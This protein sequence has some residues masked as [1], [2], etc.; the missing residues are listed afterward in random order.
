M[1]EEEEKPVEQPQTIDEK[2][3]SLY[4]DKGGFGSL[5]DTY[6]D[7]KRKYPEIKLKDVQTWYRKNVDFNIV[8]R[9]QNSF[10]AQKPHQEYQLDL[11]N[12]RGRDL[13]YTMGVACID[14]FSKFA[15]VVALADKK[16]E[17]LL[18]AIQ[19]VFQ[20]MGA[21]PLVLMSDEEGSLQS[22]LAD[23]YL[24][25]EK[26]KYIINRNH[27]PFVE[28]FIRTFR[29][30]VSRR[31]QKRPDEKWYDLLFEVLSIYNY[32]MVN[33]TT[34]LKPSEAVKRDNFAEAKMNMEHHAKHERK[35]D[36]IKVGDR[37]R[38]YRKRKRVGEKEEVPVWS[39]VAVEVLRIEKD[40][41]AGQLFYVAGSG[42]KPYIRS[43]VLKAT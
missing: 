36:E 25:R 31:L 18:E 32:K 23:A 39:K 24:K 11:F 21:K 12:M 6:N 30:L 41:V 42:D 5:K 37:V 29:N 33:R 4:L 40:P 15:T 10:V 22:K 3:A 38:L 28:R 20:K 16:P 43:Q 27:C 34:D 13:E 9:G 8:Q 2:I 7:V 26:V 19:R 14:V 1:E 35:Y 17:T